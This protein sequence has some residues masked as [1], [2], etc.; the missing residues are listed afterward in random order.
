MKDK[1]EIEWIQQ[2]N[3]AF[4]YILYRGDKVREE[5]DLS[6]NRSED[7]LIQL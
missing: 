7:Y 1:I 4:L 2:H 3:P 5:D 6:V